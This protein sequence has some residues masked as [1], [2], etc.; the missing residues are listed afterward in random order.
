MKLLNPQN[1]LLSLLNKKHVLPGEHAFCY[2]LTCVAFK[3]SSALAGWE[4]LIR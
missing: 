3:S 4:F 1:V 2:E